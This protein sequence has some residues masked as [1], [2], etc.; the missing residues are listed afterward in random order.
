VQVIQ[1]EQP[2]QGVILRPAEIALAG[3]E[4]LVIDCPDMMDLATS[5][6]QAVKQR[7]SDLETMRK[8]ITRPIDEAKAKIMDLFRP[9]KETYERTETVLKAKMVEYQLAERRR[10]DEEQRRQDEAARQARDAAAR[11]AA[12]KEA[13]ARAEAE[14]FQREA[15]EAVKAGDAGRAAELE[16][17]AQQTVATAQEQA[18][19]IQMAAAVIPTPAVVAPSV[20]KGLSLRGKW[21]ARVVDKARVVAFVAA[22]PEY[23]EILAIDESALNKLAGALQKKLPIDGVEPYEDFTAAV[24][25]RAA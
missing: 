10:A 17:A 18:A 19:E 20:P 25:R 22:H 2:E 16:V 23:L 3:A 12:S 11:E 8:A 5:E 4:A 24:S 6:T 13:A 7:L 14:R 21:K 15:A 9:A 1:Y